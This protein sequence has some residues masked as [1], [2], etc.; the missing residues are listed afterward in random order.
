MSCGPESAHIPLMD[1]HSTPLRTYSE[2]L[3]VSGRIEAYLDDVTSRAAGWIN[4]NTGY[5]VDNS[6]AGH[7]DAWTAS[8]VPKLIV[9][10]D[11]T[12]RVLL[13]HNSEEFEDTVI[14]VPAAVIPCR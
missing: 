13:T 8:I 1:T 3:Q 12:F 5:V 9:D 6:F 10:P 7:P 14:S 2:Y 11:D 4:E